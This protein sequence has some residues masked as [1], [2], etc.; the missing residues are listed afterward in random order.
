MFSFVLTVFEID[1]ILRRATGHEHPEIKSKKEI[2]PKHTRPPVNCFCAAV[3]RRKC[4]APGKT[5]SC[6]RVS[7][8]IPCDTLE[9]APFSRI[10]KFEKYF[11]DVSK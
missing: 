4:F 3:M 2:F 11:C 8:S 6:E 7:K 9:N 5:P 1:C 10:T